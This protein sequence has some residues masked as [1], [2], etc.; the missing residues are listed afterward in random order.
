MAKYKLTNKAVEDLANIWNYT[1]DKCTEQ[2]ADNYYKMLISLVRKLQI[3][4]VQEKPITELLK[5]YLE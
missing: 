3:I 2:Q 5:I 4:R 1:F